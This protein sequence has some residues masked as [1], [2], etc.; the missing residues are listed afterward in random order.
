MD[1]IK[2]ESELGGLFHLANYFAFPEKKEFVINTFSDM[3]AK[4]LSECDEYWILA[5]STAYYNHGN[6]EDALK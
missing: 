4:N 3:F 5:G 6:I 2:P 1:E